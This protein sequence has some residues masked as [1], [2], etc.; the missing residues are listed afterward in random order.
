MALAAL[1]IFGACA[2]QPKPEAKTIANHSYT[3]QAVSED[4]LR[5]DVI[6]SL[7]YTYTQKAI[8]DYYQRYLKVTPGSAPYLDKMLSVGETADA[9][10]IWKYTIKLEV[11]PYLGPHNNVGTDD[12]TFKVDT[13]GEVKL[14]KFEHMESSKILPELY[15]DI[16]REWPPK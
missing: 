4:R 9:N 14:A 7:L 5:G 15:P 11:Y 2:M 12:I 6:V 13:I 16:I 8:D 3:V 10:D 1:F